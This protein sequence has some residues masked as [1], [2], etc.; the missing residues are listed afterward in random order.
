MAKLWK[1][2]AF[3]AKTET[4]QNSVAALS[5]SDYIGAMDF[6]ITPV[7]EQISD[8]QVRTVLGSPPN[9]PG[10]KNYDVTAQWKLKGAGSAGSM[11]TGVDALFYACALSGSVVGGTSVTYKPT[12]VTP[13]GFETPAKTCTVVGNYQ[14]LHHSV[15]GVAGSLKMSF[16]AGQ[17]IIVDFSG[18]GLWSSCTDTQLPSGSYGSTV[19]PIVQ[20]IQFQIGNYQ[21]T[22]DKFEFDLGNSLQMYD[23]VNSAHGVAFMGVTDRNPVGS[24]SA[25]AVNVAEHDFFGRMENGTVASGSI[26]VGVSNGNK[27]QF[28]FTSIQYSNVQYAN[29]NGFIDVQATLKFNDTADNWLTLIAL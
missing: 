15:A 8:E 9:I 11:L 26:L 21:F 19:A 7:V 12:S 1:L 27:F 2:R 22:A 6:T 28:L 3:G 10:K 18:K 14:G 13:S 17:P 23:G 4:V 25:K 16:A 29:K 24:F 5:A 20:S